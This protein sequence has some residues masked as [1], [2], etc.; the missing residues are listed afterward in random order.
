[1]GT[2]SHLEFSLSTDPG[3]KAAS[4]GENTSSLPCAAIAA[5]TASFFIVNNMGSR[6]HSNSADLGWVVQK[7]GGT[8]VGKFPIK[9]NTTVL[10]QLMS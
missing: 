5:K 1:V 10:F 2:T 6:T 4:Q 3:L 7:F 8:S 9:V